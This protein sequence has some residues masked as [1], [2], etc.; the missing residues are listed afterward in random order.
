MKK[1]LQIEVEQFKEMIEAAHRLFH[2]HNWKPKLSRYISFNTRDILYECKC[3]K[4][5]IET[6]SRDFDT[7]FPIETAMMITHKEM[8]DALLNGV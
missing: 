6:V 8:Q 2:I 5:K 1:I 7:P 4:R 3:W